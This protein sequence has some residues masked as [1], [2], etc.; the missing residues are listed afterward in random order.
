MHWK[1]WDKVC[2]DKEDGGLGFKEIADFN[3][4]M[5]AKQLWRLIEKP[6]ALFSRVFKGRYFR[7]A[8]PLDPIRSYSPSY[9]WRSISSARSLR[10]DRERWHFN[11]NGKYSVKSGY[12]VERVYPDVAK[13]PQVLGPTVD[14]LKAH[15]CIAVRKNLH[16]RGLTGDICCDRCGAPE[17]SINHVFFECPPARQVWALSQIPSNPTI[18]PTES[19]YTNMDHLFWRVLPKMDDHHFAWILWYIWK[20]RNNKVFSNLDIDPSETLKIAV[21]E[22]KIREDAQ[23]VATSV[24]DRP[25]PDLPVIP[26]RWCFIDGSWKDKEVYSGQGWYSTLQGFAGLMGARNVRASLSPFHSEVEALIWAME[27]MRNL[28]QFRVTFATDCSQL[29]KMVSEPEEWPAF[30]AYLEDIKTLQNNFHS[31]DIIYV[32]RT[33][34]RKADGLARGAR[35]QASFVVHMDE[36]P[37]TWFTES[38]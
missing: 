4:A 15:W 11:Q 37:P 22:A 24:I 35:T 16:A 5:L 3:T 14:V 28:H 12:Q 23:S 33:H 6:N 36:K 9:G 7:N 29:V 13:P 20:G 21:T 27:C 8:S 38:V 25:I 31:S 18:F 19:L 2:L 26:G 32:S 34:N 10:L 17:E 1:S 30:A